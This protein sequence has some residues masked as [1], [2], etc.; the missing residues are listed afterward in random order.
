MLGCFKMLLVFMVVHRYYID[1]RTRN[2]ANAFVVKKSYSS[3]VCNPTSTALYQLQMSKPFP[4]SDVLV[5]HDRAQ[6]CVDH[7]GSCTIAEME[8]LKNGMHFGFALLDL[9]SRTNIL[10][11]APRLYRLSRGTYAKLSVRCV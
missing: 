8:S 7:F 1:D 6:Y 4:E 10:T 9:C 2:M 5:D 3:N 11:F